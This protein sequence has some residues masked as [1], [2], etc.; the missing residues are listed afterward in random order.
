MNESIKQL[1]MCA[2]GW[3]DKCAHSS[4][5]NCSDIIDHCERELAV[6]ELE[7]RSMKQVKDGSFMNKPT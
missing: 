3:C 1:G 5:G 2:R 6:M 7:L 4:D